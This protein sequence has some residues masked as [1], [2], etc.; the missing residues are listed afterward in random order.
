MIYTLHSALSGRKLNKILI[1]TREKHSQ[2][3]DTDYFLRLSK[4]PTI[5]T[6][7][8]LLMVLEKFDSKM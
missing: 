1:I 7:V 6:T 3:E 2:F 5:S 4:L 8:M